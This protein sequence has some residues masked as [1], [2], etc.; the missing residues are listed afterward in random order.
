MTSQ[1]IPGTEISLATFIGEEINTEA[2]AGALGAASQEAAQ[3]RSKCW[4]GKECG[5]TAL[6]EVMGDAKVI[7]RSDTIGVGCEVEMCPN[8][9]GADWST[10]AE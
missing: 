6:Q 7:A 9:H 8:L 2:I 4:M 1:F 5:A 10:R 3:I